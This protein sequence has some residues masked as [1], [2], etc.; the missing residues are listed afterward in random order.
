MAKT[1]PLNNSLGRS[2]LPY[3]KYSA[4]NPTIDNG[5]DTVI[6]ELFGQLTIVK[7]EFKLTFLAQASHRVFI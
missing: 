6:S 2:L 4:T 5:V 1:T 7:N 3:L